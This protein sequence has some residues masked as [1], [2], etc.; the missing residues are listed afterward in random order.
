MRR[1]DK[2]IDNSDI[3]Q[4]LQAGEYGV[5]STVDSNQQPYG[6]ILLKRV[7]PAAHIG[8]WKRSSRKPG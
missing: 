4:L 7:R 1:K 3:I 6:V 8:G 5:L 2:A